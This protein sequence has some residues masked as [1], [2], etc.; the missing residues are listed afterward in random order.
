MRSHTRLY[1]QLK[2]KLYVSIESIKKDAD[3]FAV[4]GLTEVRIGPEGFVITRVFK[5][6]STKCDIFVFAFLPLCD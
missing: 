2:M 3:N 5:A 1:D 4:Y 6:V